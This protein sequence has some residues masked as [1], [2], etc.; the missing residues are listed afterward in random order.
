LSGQI[1][2]KLQGSQ[3]TEKDDRLAGIREI[4]NGI[5]GK[6]LKAVFIEW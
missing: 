2:G 1:K 3:I 6:V 5:S 4:V